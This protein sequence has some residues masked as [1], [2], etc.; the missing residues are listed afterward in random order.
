MQDGILETVLRLLLYVYLMVLL[1]A[2][3]DGPGQDVAS[4]SVTVELLNLVIWYNVPMNSC[5]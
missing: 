2:V 3:A 1:M 5:I 4:T